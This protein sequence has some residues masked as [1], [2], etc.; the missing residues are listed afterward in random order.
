MMNEF[1]TIKKEEYESLIADREMLEDIQAYDEAINNLEEGMPHD[2][3]V[4]M[5]VDGENPLA[6]YREWRGFNQSSLAKASG[7]NRTQIA[8]IEAG[9]SKPSVVTLKKLAV[10]L[11]VDMDDLV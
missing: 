8:D 2:L 11:D 3:V 6:I 5:I 7:V 1:V 4:R 10:T 9:R